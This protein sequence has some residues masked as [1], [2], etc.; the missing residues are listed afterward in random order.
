MKHCFLMLFVPV[1]LVIT[2]GCQTTAP[3][4]AKAMPRISEPKPQSL[5][6]LTDATDARKKKSDH[7]GRQTF[8]VFMIPTFSVQS[9]DPLGK[10]VGKVFSEALTQSGYEVKPV[11]TLDEAD[12]PVLAIQVDSF[13]NYLF[14]W[15]WP[16]GLTGGRAEL[17][18]VVFDSEG[19]VLW[20]GEPC[21]GWGGCPS[22]AYM[23]GFETSVKMEMT[24]IMRDA[25]AQFSTPAFVNVVAPASGQ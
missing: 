5:C 2:S 19:K 18:P 15:L 11:A 17:T 13:R 1:A 12:G 22:V 8:S 25:V 3:I 20:K 7:V 23:A 14:A 21:V 24:S 6:V 16:L 9:E 10:E 4:K